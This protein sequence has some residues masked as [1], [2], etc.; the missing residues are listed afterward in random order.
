MSTVGPDR[1]IPCNNYT[2][3]DADGC[4]KLRIDPKDNLEPIAFPTHIKKCCQEGGDRVALAVKRE[5]KW[6]KWTYNQ[7]YVDIRTAA[8][9]F[10]KL[11]LEPFHSV[12]IYGFNS[13]EWF[14]SALGGI[15]C[16]GF[17]CGLYPTNSASMNKFI[18]QDSSANILVCED[19]AAV[20]KMWEIVEE[21]ET[22]KKVI[23]FSGEPKRPGVL[24]WKEF[25]NE[26]KEETDKELEHRLRNMAVNQC[27]VLIYTSGTT[28]NPK[29][30]MLSHDNIL[31]ITRAAVICYK[32][33]EFC[34]VFLSFLPLSHIAAFMFDMM[35][36]LT[37]KATTYFADKMALKG[38]LL[39]YLKEVRPTHFLGVP[40]VWE[41][42]MEGMLAKGKDIKG[43]KKKIS[44]AC[45][46][47]GIDHHLNHKTGIMY[48]VGKKVVY[49][50]VR[51]ALGLDRTKNFYTGAAPL[52]PETFK[53][54]L[55]LDIH[56]L[57]I[58]GMSETSGLH[59]G[60]TPGMISMGTVGKPS[61]LNQI[62]L[63]NV[64]ESG[65]GEMCM[66]GR[67]I[68]MGYLHREDKTNEDIDEDGYL[69]SGD[70]AFVDDNG[71]VS[72]T[73]KNL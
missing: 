10:I 9:A 70:L 41:K 48:K 35:A 2:T 36:P 33:E 52:S 28:G 57:E 66:R 7:Y 32:L 14:I 13:P 23:Q 12:A 38:T 26:G 67:N 61:Y 4:V 68:M 46:Q 30:V 29:G 64:N 8:K 15:Y 51:E 31:Y 71:I 60:T 22:L 34:E 63:A 18:M 65:E 47:A 24:S 3:V 69:H 21:V 55:S 20:D 59:I 5:G 45:K 37:I 25:M 49:S 1:I 62:K 58:Y 6:V 16:G 56:I 11:G 72:I 17:S 19:A 73:G 44:V 43:L 53:Y 54:F 39:E 40:R 50:K 42:I 27:A